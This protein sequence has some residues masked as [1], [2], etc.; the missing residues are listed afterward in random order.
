MKIKKEIKMKIRNGFVSNSSSSSFVLIGEKVKLE[1]I[2]FTDG[3]EYNATISGLDDE[4]GDMIVV[5][6]ESYKEVIKNAIEFG[7]YG[8][9][10]L[11]RTFFLQYEGG[12]MLNTA[13]LPK[14]VHVV[15]G[16]CSMHSPQSA[17]ELE[18]MMKGEY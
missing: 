1:D 14:K 18:G 3:F 13:D 12:G 2:D 15:N 17:K 6:D 5:L 9:L 11:Y 8:N 16:E 7:F 10:N 4:N